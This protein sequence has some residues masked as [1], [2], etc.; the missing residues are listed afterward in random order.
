MVYNVRVDSIA[1][2]IDTEVQKAILEF[3]ET[4]DFRYVTCIM[5]KASLRDVFIEHF[6]NRHDLGWL[7]QKVYLLAQKEGRNLRGVAAC[8]WCEPNRVHTMALGTLLLSKGIKECCTVHSYS[9]SI[10]MSPIC[11]K[12][13]EGK[14]LDIQQVINN[15]FPKTY[16]ELM[17]TDVPMIPQHV[18]CRHIMAPLEV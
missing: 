12:N 15:S 1:R 2:D 9:R 14:H 5:D 7:K 16:Q 11:F 13:L 4:Y 17:R 3:L 18:N 8:A 6:K 10:P